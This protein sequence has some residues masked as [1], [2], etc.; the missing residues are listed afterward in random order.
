MRTVL[1]R[2]QLDREPRVDNAIRLA[3]GEQARLVEAVGVERRD[4]ALVRFEHVGIRREPA[5][6]EQRRIEAGRC[7][8]AAV[9]A[10]G[11]RADIRQQRA[12]ARSSDAER[13]PHA[14]HVQPQ[15]F[16]CDDG[17]AERAGEAR[18]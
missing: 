9:R 12:G 1:R 14:V 11:H 7:R 16:R 6:R 15:Q 2:K 3:E 17:A 13:V 18:R 5:L 8:V 4:H 10:L